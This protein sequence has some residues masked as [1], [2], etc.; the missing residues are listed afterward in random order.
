MDLG[1]WDPIRINE[2]ATSKDRIAIASEAGL[3]IINFNTEAFRLYNIGSG[4]PSNRVISLG[5]F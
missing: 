5:I 3:A 4:L 1:S 2:M